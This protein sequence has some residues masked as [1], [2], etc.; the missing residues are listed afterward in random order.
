MKKRDPRLD[1]V[2]LRQLHLTSLDLKN[3]LSIISAMAD[4]M[5]QNISRVKEVMGDVYSNEQI[6][7]ALNFHQ[8]DFEKA[9]N[10]LLEGPHEEIQS[11]PTDQ[12]RQSISDAFNSNNKSNITS[13]FPW[14]NRESNTITTTW[15]EPDIKLPPSPKFSSSD[16]QK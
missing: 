1:L 12:L 16:Q 11:N 7:K 8:N 2:D 9:L 6:I 15:G 4:L 13:T 14:D 5:D 3:Y 10:Y